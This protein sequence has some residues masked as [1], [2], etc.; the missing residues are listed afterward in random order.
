MVNSNIGGGIAG[1][2]NTMS[3]GGGGGGTPT[4]ISGL[5]TRS[6]NNLQLSSGTPTLGQVLQ[7][8]HTGIIAG[9]VILDGL[10]PDIVS[11]LRNAARITVAVG[12]HGVR[13]I[14]V[15]RSINPTDLVIT[16]PPEVIGINN[17]E[18]SVSGVINSCFTA[19]LTATNADGDITITLS[20]SINPAVSQTIT[21]PARTSGGGDGNGNGNGNGGGD[22]VERTVAVVATRETFA[23]GTT[24]LLLNNAFREAAGID[25]VSL[26]DAV[27]IQIRFPDLNINNPDPKVAIESSI[28]NYNDIDTYDDAM[29]S[30]QN[31]ARASLFIIP[32]TSGTSQAEA[33]IVLSVL[34][35]EGNSMWILSSVPTPGTGEYTF[36]KIVH[37]VTV[38]IQVGDSNVIPADDVILAQL[39]VATASPSLAALTWFEIPSV[40]DTTLTADVSFVEINIPDLA[41]AAD[42][43]SPFHLLMPR[44]VFDNLAVY[45]SNQSNVENR[46]RSWTVPV[47]ITFQDNQRTRSLFVLKGTNDKS[48]Y[49]ELPAAEFIPVSGTIQ[50][51]GKRLRSSLLGTG[52]STQFASFNEPDNVMLIT[53]IGLTHNSLLLHDDQFTSLFN[54]EQTR[55]DSYLVVSVTVTS[56]TDSY[57]QFLYRT[58]PSVFAHFSQNIRIG[59]SGESSTLVS[60]SEGLALTNSDPVRWEIGLES[61]SGDNVTFT[62]ITIQIRE[63]VILGT[64][65][66]ATGS[67]LLRTV[68]APNSTV[69]RMD[70]AAVEFVF[71]EPVDLRTISFIHFRLAYNDRDVTKVYTSD[72]IAEF[73]VD[74]TGSE[75]QVHTTALA[76]R[77]TLKIVIADYIL[78]NNASFGVNAVL[79]STIPH[80]KAQFTKTTD[81]VMHGITFFDSMFPTGGGDLT[82]EIYVL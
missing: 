8:G 23:R 12:A 32:R 45:D 55:E 75:F 77:N 42:T 44:S 16:V 79:P 53:E 18:A 39:D 19:A 38:P 56:A 7:Q 34:R 2:S 37:S 57:A 41:A 76:Q 40:S 4:D 60:I 22:T 70:E 65:A 31:M 46:R 78:R 52:S 11:T 54:Y 81:Y 29:T 43:T 48:L 63:Y 51:I 17:L 33:N 50:V 66:N 36:E 49:M 68:L 47:G 64:T 62:D 72:R 6:L 26:D 13:D 58:S 15:A 9:E 71:D 1:G 21:I 25:G 82:V 67:K 20:N 69:P 10:D 35:G 28:L 27:Q 73:L 59:G 5:A 80:I 61:I 14:T 74:R 3:I 24:N 30:E